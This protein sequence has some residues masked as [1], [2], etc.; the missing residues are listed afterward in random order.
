MTRKAQFDISLPA[1]IPDSWAAKAGSLVAV[2][3]VTPP[4]ASAFSLQDS[5]LS[6]R[7]ETSK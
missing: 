4:H 2:T 3:E 5:E 7:K 1:A 6:L